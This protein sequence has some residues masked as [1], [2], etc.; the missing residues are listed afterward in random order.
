[1]DIKL[2]N[3]NKNTLEDLIKGPQ[4]Y[5][6]D[7]HYENVYGKIYI[8]CTIHDG[9]YHYKKEFW[10]SGGPAQTEDEAFEKAL[11]ILNKVLFLDNIPCQPDLSKQ[12]NQ[13]GYYREMIGEETEVEF[14]R[15]ENHYV[16]TNIR[17][18]DKDGFYSLDN[19]YPVEQNKT[20]YFSHILD[21]GD[22][23]YKWN[24]CRGLSGS[25]GEAIIRNGMVIKTKG[26]GLS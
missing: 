8:T 12:A 13:N 4:H 2:E 22:D 19:P 7:F 15:V 1:L 16:I 18:K 9:Y 14:K 21:N 5:S 23:L 24:T 17:R 20:L 6:V 10:V 25:W 11:I 3:N 26:I